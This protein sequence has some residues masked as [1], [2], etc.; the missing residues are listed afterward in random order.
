LEGK[1]L[2]QNFL[3][4][5]IGKTSAPKTSIAEK[6]PGRKVS[7]GKTFVRGKLSR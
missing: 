6:V 2:R 1:V 7:W 3:G 4:K 5:L